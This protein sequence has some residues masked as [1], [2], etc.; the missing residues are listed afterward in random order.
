MLSRVRFGAELLPIAHSPNGWFRSFLPFLCL[1]HHWAP[2]IEGLLR[3]GCRFKARTCE[4]LRVVQDGCPCAASWVSRCGM[5]LLTLLSTAR[6]GMSGSIPVGSCST[7][8]RNLRLEV[9][10]RSELAMNLRSG[11]TRPG[12]VREAAQDRNSDFVSRYFS[13]PK[14]R[15]ESSTSCPRRASWSSLT[16]RPL[17]AFRTPLITLSRLNGSTTH[18]VSPDQLHLF[19][20]GEP[21]LTGWALTPASDA[22]PI[23]SRPRV[24]HLG[25]G[26]ATVRA[27][28]LSGSFLMLES[29]QIALEGQIWG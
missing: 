4:S 14:V 27:V 16:G 13:W 10:H 15:S 20:G 22:R 8:Q 7:K 24:E 28:Q 12:Q 11:G 1:R 29:L 18:C 2:M 5:K 17:Q 23:V 21:P 3:I 25:V 19:D 26:M 6:S 9:L